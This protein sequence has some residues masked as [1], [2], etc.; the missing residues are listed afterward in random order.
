MVNKVF[1]LNEAI[2]IQKWLTIFDAL[3]WP[4][5]VF[6]ENSALLI[7]LAKLQVIIS[8][9]HVWPCQ[10]D[11]PPLAMA[12]PTE[13]LRAQQGPFA[14]ELFRESVQDHHGAFLGHLPEDTQRGR[15][16]AGLGPAGR[17]PSSWGKS[18]DPTRLKALGTSKLLAL[19]GGSWRFLAVPDASSMFLLQMTTFPMDRLQ[20]TVQA[21]IWS[22][23]CPAWPTRLR[24]GTLG[25]H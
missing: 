17:G 10:L 20:F 16:D 9:G 25:L 22:V 11:F 15:L 12:T 7:A 1:K 8:P 14:Q 13:T 6:M 2:V 24:K 3:Y 21:P 5:L 4:V 23:K 19:P 18:G